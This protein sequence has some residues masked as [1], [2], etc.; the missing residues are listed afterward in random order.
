MVRAGREVQEELDHE[1]AL[2]ERKVAEE[3]RKLNERKDDVL[4]QKQKQHE[5]L[6]DLRLAR[7]QA[8]LNYDMEL[9]TEKRGL[10]M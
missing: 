2:E 4:R 1:I 7:E 6:T 5:E 10:Q 9:Q 3:E 8:V